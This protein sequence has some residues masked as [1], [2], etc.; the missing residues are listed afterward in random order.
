MRRKSDYSTD[1][2]CKP[3]LLLIVL[4]MRKRIHNLDA[5]NDCLSMLWNCSSHL[6]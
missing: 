3:T 1:D 4:H 6:A 5:L 2:G